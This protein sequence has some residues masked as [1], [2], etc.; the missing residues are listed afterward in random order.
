MTEMTELAARCFG[1]ASGLALAWSVYPSKPSIRN[2]VTVMAGFMI[3]VV[4]ASI[5]RSLVTETIG[6]HIPLN[7]E[8]LFFAASLCG[9]FIVPFVHSV[10]YFIEKYMG[11]PNE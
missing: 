1:S 9:I 10:K 5:I 11:K 8:G 2:A 3:S 4:S 7:H 6:I